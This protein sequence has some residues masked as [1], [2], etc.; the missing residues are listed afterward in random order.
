LLAVGPEG[1][2]ND[3]ELG[4]LEAHGFQRFS[5]GWQT[6]RTDTAC[7]ALLAVLQHSLATAPTP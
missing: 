6:L 7:I 1:G 5:L 2:W 3:F 4:L